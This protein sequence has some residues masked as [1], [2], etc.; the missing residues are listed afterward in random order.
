MIIFGYLPFA[1]KCPFF[2]GVPQE[3][4]GDF[5]YYNPIIEFEKVPLQHLDFV[6]ETGTS[7]FFTIFT[8]LFL[9]ICT[10]KLIELIL[11]C[12]EIIS[13]TVSVIRITTCETTGRNGPT[14]EN[15]EK[16][17]NTDVELLMPSSTEEEKGSPFNL[18]G[19]QRWTAPRGEYYTLVDV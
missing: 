11:H 13:Y 15:C 1:H 19:V 16:F 9:Y 14:T 7:Y 6:N 4:V 5:N 18:K 3:V 17:N 2:T 8:I 10:K 12:Y